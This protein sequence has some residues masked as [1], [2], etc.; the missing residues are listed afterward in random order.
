MT[1]LEVSPAI[2]LVDQIA[3]IKKATADRLEQL[4]EIRVSAILD[5]KANLQRIDDE[6]AAL[7]PKQKRNRKPKVAADGK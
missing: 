2:P 7:T 6:V 1:D 5:H 4:A 3:A